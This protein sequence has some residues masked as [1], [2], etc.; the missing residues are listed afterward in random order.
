MIR[1]PGCAFIRKLL[2]VSIKSASFARTFYTLTQPPWAAS[3]RYPVQINCTGIIKH[4]RLRRG[5]DERRVQ[6]YANESVT[7]YQAV[8]RRLALLLLV[9]RVLADNHNLAL[10][11]NDL[12]L[13]ADRLYRRSY[14]HVILPPSNFWWD[15]TPE[16]C[17]ATTG[18]QVTCV[19][20]PAFYLTWNAK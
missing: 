3:F 17:P 16:T 20:P 4:D 7:K 9:L 1:T 5:T 10:T 19:P 6:R 12:A 2:A 15:G 13:L 18:A 8:R 11:A 14:L